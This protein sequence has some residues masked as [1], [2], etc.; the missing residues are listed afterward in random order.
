MPVKLRLRRQG[1]KGAPFYSIVAADARAPR[2]GKYI[3]RVGHYNPVKEPA[4]VFV[5]HEI[6]I[7]WLR[8]GAQPTHTVKSLLRH[9]GVNL[10]FAL[11]KQ[12]KPEAEVERIVGK[13]WNEKQSKDK[14]KIVMVDVH[15]RLIK[16]LDQLAGKEEVVAEK[17]APTPAPAPVSTEA[18]TESEVEAAPV[19]EEA[20][21]AAEAEAA[22]EATPEAPASEE[23]PEK[24]AE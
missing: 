23:A 6:A 16:N 17:A 2:D 24:A 20:A 5:D 13:W 15:G 14:K 9:A 11:L 12:G 7:K 8:N 1:R 22:P 4:Q 10:K 3:E 19:V 18:P 21:P